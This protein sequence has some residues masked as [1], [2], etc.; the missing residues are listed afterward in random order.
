MIGVTGTGKSA[1]ANSLI[2]TE[3]FKT[4][5]AAQSETDSVQGVLRNWL[6]QPEKGPVIVLD[7]P[8][9]GDSRNKDTGHIAQIVSRLKQVGYVNTFVIVLNSQDPRFDE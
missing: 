6:G 1:T 9:M 3:Y 7:T 8:G 2:G 4:S 5:A